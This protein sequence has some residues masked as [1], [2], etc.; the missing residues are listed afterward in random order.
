M[1]SPKRVSFLIL[2][3]GLAACGPGGG[4]GDDDDTG[5]DDDDEIICHGDALTAD[6]PLSDDLDG[7]RDR[8]DVNKELV[9]ILFVGE[10]L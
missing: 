3:L 6:V 9:R 10:P 4:G 1:L 7:L 8:W 2:A 5:P